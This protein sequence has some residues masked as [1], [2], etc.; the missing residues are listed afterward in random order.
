ML[1]IAEATVRV[2]GG[3]AL[4]GL[5]GTGKRELVICGNICPFAYGTATCTRQPDFTDVNR[6]TTD[7]FDVSFN[8]V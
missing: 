3:P 1:G 6:S 5:I 2:N 4:F 8:A 7:S